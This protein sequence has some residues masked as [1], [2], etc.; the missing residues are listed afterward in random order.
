MKI[1]DIKKLTDCK[2]L[3]LYKLDIENKV[4]NSKEYFIASRRTEEDLS[5]VVNKHDK[6]DGVMIIPIT[7][8]DEFVLLK[9]FRPAINDYIYEF[10]A[11]LIDNG[12][13]A[14]KAATRELFEET[15]LLA[16]ESEYLIK[17]SYTSVGM[18]DE[19]V[20]VVK[21]KVYGNISTENLEE[22][23][24]IEVIKVPRKEA[25]NFVKENNVSIKTALVLSF[26]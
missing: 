17:P 16:S 4:G 26:T 11:G 20:A 24:E 25:K 18:S 8:N 21:M 19:S 6:A 22:N 10:P 1:K 14:I 3:N 23:E 2:F 12:E 13:D 15:G 7:E 5:C 9:Q